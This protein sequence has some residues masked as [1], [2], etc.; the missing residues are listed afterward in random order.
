MLL[1]VLAFVLFFLLAFRGY[2]LFF[3]AILCAFLCSLATPE[4]FGSIFSTFMPAVGTNASSLLL[5]YALGGAFGYCLMESGVADT[6]ATHMLKVFGEK[7]VPAAIFFLT[8]V[9]VLAGV[10][11]YQYTIV[12][13]AIPLLKKLNLPRK[14]ALAAMSAGGGSVAYGILAGAPSNLNIA[15]TLYLGTTTFAGAGISAVCT[16]VA[17][18]FIIAWLN[19]LVK[20]ARRTSE[21]FESYPDDEF[22]NKV[23]EGRT[24]V[25]PWKGYVCVFS[26]IVFSLFF[27][28]VLMLKATSAVVYSEIMAIALCRLL[29]GGGNLPSPIKSASKGFIN[30]IP[31]ILAIC[32]VS[33]FSS[34]VKLTQGFSW[35]VNSVSNMEM[36]PYL[37]AF[38]S[39]NVFAGMTA[40]GY[41]GVNMFMENFGQEIANNPLINAGAMH[42]ICSIAGC[43]MDSLPNNGAISFQLSVFRLSYRKG[44]FQQ[45]M[46]S[47]VVNML[48]GLLA[49]VIAVIL[50]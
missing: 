45:F 3:V 26:V 48:V 5:R 30:S 11:S 9:L 2:S 18:V 42:R 25:A 37:L 6:I 35:V 22:E 36:N 41:S 1:I 46:M 39:V 27:Q 7:R 43:G 24:T 10:Q 47:V 34:I 19:H 12:A 29:V 17:C 21:G 8:C 14:I 4:G 38:L 28:Y 33:G 23:F 32:F 15:P 16:I 31:P 20:K 13:I 40:N 44:Y 49:V 50:Y